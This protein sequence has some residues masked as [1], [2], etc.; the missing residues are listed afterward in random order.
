M[1]FVPNRYKW[2]RYTAPNYAIPPDSAHWLCPICAQ[3]CPKTGV[4]GHT[5]WVY[6]FGKELN[7]LSASVQSKLL[8]P[9]NSGVQILTLIVFSS[10][11][12]ASSNRSIRLV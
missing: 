11:G 4:S 3:W 2:A 7:D 1:D 9:M 12:L 6:L 10:N 5:P 8:K